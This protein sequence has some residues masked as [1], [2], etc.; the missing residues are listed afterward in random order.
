MSKKLKLYGYQE[1]ITKDL[2]KVLKTRDDA[3]CT[4]SMGAGKSVIIMALTEIFQ[5]EKKTIV[6]LTN[7]SRLIS[8]LSTHL[9]NFGIEFNVIKSK[10]YVIDNNINVWLVMEQ[11]FHPKKQAELNLK[12]IDILIKDEFHIGYNQKRYNQII[13]YLAPSKIIAFSGTPFDEKGY[14]LEGFDDNNIVRHAQ[15]QDLIKD[16]FLVP[17]KYFIP[18]WSEKIDYSGVKITGNDYS[19]EELNAVLNNSTHLELTIQSMNL[20]NAKRKKTLVYANDIQHATNVFN[21]LISEGYKVG[22]IHSKNKDLENEEYLEK[23]SKDN[24]DIDCLVSVSKLTTGFDEPKAELLVLLRPTKILR[25]YLQI[26]FRVARIYKGK[27]YSEILDLAKCVATH[28]FAEEYR[29]YILKGDKENLNKE[30]QRVEKNVMLDV[31]DSKDDITPGI[32]NSVVVKVKLKE[33]KIKELNLEYE[34]FNKLMIVFGSTMDLD[35]IIH[36]GFEINKRTHNILYKK[37]DLELLICKL[38]DRIGNNHKEITIVKQD[39][40]AAVRNKK[41]LFNILL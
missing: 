22:I 1:I 37:N 7:I 18:K 39:I 16:G 33:L 26:A 14:L 3:L 4:A 11:S 40:Q 21:R 10:E 34:K 12:N 17:L 19:N 36:I 27:K 29:N 31:I 15:P 28:G 2:L 8:Q 30:K 25:L 5:N 6:I 24:S 20:M 38:K 41:D 13:D 9:E 32:I 35:I 23:F